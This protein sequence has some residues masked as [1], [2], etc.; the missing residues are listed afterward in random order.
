MITSVK[1]ELTFNKLNDI[2]EEIW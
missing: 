1:F 2:F